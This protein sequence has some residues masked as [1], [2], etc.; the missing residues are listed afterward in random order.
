MSYR[1]IALR[2][3][4]TQTQSSA[5]IDRRTAV[6]CNRSLAQYRAA[7][8]ITLR[9]TIS[10]TE[11][12]SVNNELCTRARAIVT[13]VRSVNSSANPSLARVSF[14]MVKQHSTSQSR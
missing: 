5:L 9:F 10:D 12:T 2:D 6:V 4:Q 8:T 1:L 13:V 7:L 11:R 3:Q 14:Q